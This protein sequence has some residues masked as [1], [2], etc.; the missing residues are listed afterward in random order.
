MGA[1]ISRLLENL[2]ANEQDRSYKLH[3]VALEERLNAPWSESSISVAEHDKDLDDEGDVGAVWLE[4]SV[5]RKRFSVQSLHLCSFVV[6]EESGW[7]D[8]VVDDT[9]SSGETDKPVENLGWSV[10]ALQERKHREE[11]HDGEAIDWH[12]IW[13][14]L[15][16][17]AWSTAFE[18]KS[19]QRSSGT[20]GISIA[21]REDGCQH[22]RVDNIRQNR[23]A[24]PLHGND[25]G[26]SGSSA[27]SFHAVGDIL[28]SFVIP[29]HNNTNAKG[30][31]EEEDC[32]SKVDGL[33]GGLD[34]N[35]GALG[36]SSN[37]GDVL[38]A[39][40][41]ERRVPE[42]LQESLKS[43]KAAFGVKLGECARAVPVAEPISVVL[44]VT[45][46]HS[47]KGVE[48]EEKD[49]N[50]FASR[51]PEFSFTVATHG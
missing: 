20:V 35:A 42:S 7:H 29:R 8:E 43:A 17:E 14:A 49:Q 1:N 39:N 40:T 27:T 26:R 11:H 3:G 2:P 4:V 30:T 13:R 50:D 12:T 32:K 33:E 18:G 37:H 16:E 19:V 21:G 25:V 48:E 44:R 51:K 46:D 23:D 38:W 22:Q 6:E 9:T 24:H 41:G 10:A 28:K 36:L 45:A 5:V 31:A 47:N 15:A 34:V